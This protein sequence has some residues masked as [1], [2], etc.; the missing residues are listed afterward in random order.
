MAISFGVAIF[1]FIKYEANMSKEEIESLLNDMEICENNDFKEE[2]KDYDLGEVLA[3]CCDGEPKRHMLRYSDG[4][5]RIF[6]F[7]D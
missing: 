7:D 6:S 2:N 3:F 1:K 4:K 5:E